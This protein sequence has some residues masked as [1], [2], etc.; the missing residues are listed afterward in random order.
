MALQRGFH[1]PDQIFDSQVADRHPEVAAGNV[2]QFVRLVKNHRAYLREDSRV[3]CVV[4]GLLDREISEKQVMVDDDDVTLHGPAMHFGD[5]AA[6]PG[7]AFLAETG[8]GSG[9][10]LGPE[11]AGLRQGG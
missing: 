9:V 3:G 2:F 11:R 6:V 5:K 7:A 1:I 8:F 4:A 10:Q